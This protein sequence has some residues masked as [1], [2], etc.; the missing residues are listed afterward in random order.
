[1]QSIMKWCAGILLALAFGPP[2]QGGEA[3]LYEK[4]STFG[5]IVVVDE[6]DGTRALRFGRHGARQSAWRPDD[7][8]HLVLPYV[9][10]ALTALALSADPRRILVVGLGGG[11]LPGFLHRHYPD[12]HID[13]VDIDPEVVDVAK[14]YFG[15][16]ED[17]KLR[18]HV[19][20]GR[21]FIEEAREPYDLIFLDA[22]GTTAVPAHLTTREFLEAVRRATRPSGVVVGNLWF[23]QFNKLFDSMVLTYRKVFDDLAVLHVVG[24]GNRILIAVPRRNALERAEFARLAREVSSARRFRFDMGEL[25]E[26]GFHPED[27]TG[28]GGRLLLDRDLKNRGEARS[29]HRRCREPG[30]PDGAIRRSAVACRQGNSGS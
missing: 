14:K 17:A 2:A 1:M 26:R 16:R 29:S 24:T 11:T 7:P 30:A 10:V 28:E 20:D 9:E 21:R 15:F 8:D 12:A 22:F 19:A 6:A 18:A 3:V 13:A 23:R 27:A 25:V 5:T 4:T